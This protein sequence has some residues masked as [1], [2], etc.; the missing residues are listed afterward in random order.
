MKCLYVCLLALLFSSLPG[1]STAARRPL[2]ADTFVALPVAANLD[3]LLKNADRDHDHKITIRDEVKSF[4]A[5]SEAGGTLLVQGTYG[6][7]VLLQE[8]ILAKDRHESSLP[9]RVALLE[10]NPL[11][12]TSRLIEEIYWDDLTRKLD[13]AGLNR[14][15]PDS[16]IKTASG[17]AYLYVPEK[18]VFGWRYYQNLKR[19][20]PAIQFELVRLP[21]R[22]SPAFFASL[23]DRH[24]LLALKVAKGEGGEPQ[25][26]PYVVP[27]GRF[28]EMYGWDSYFILR[29]L[30]QDGK[31]NLAEAMV[32]NQ[33][34]QIEH[35]G[36][37]LNANRSYYLSRT[38]PPFFTSML[39]AVYEAKAPSPTRSEWLLKNLALAIREYREVWAARPRLVSKFNLSRYFDEGEG[40][41]PE[42]EEG[43]YDAYLSPFAKEK[44]I[45]PAAYLKLYEAGKIQDPRVR[46]LFKHDRTVRETGHDTT[47]RFDL[48]AADFLT[49]DLNSLLYKYETDIADLLDS[50]GAGS[51]KLNGR[52]ETGA[53]WRR[54]AALR[55]NRMQ[56]LLWDEAAGNFYDFDLKNNARSGFDSATALYALWAGVAT[57]DQARRVAARAREALLSKGGLA[58]SSEKSRGPLHA[59][60]RPQ[61][62]WDYPYGWPPHQI[63]AWEGLARYGMRQ[64][65]EDI[66]TAWLLAIGKNA[67]DFNGMV[68]EKYD[69]EKAS[70]EA[71]AEYGNVGSQFSY[72]TKEGFGWTNASI[73]LGRAFLPAEKLRAVEAETAAIPGK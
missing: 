61:R 52:N 40:P 57:P 35:Y 58:A 44:G 65:A 46:L 23:K 5:I 41:G 19:E 4:E 20:N 10:E 56:A 73:Q 36:K 43:A 29:G 17:L 71:F 48:R 63:L 62:Q 53:E 49:V 13:A 9:F 12:R 70:H 16:K 64:E 33:A 11:A 37:I 7:S 34:Y 66:A 60:E 69:V 38:Q 42:V 45:T 30:L 54:R 67:R 3:R 1:C 25:P 50:E 51:M 28:N 24:G 8:L 59:P 22:V 15:L 21:R 55:K 32:D 18:D 2:P 14:T 27:G 6:V 39:R 26:V 72:I 68:T 31:L 47:Y